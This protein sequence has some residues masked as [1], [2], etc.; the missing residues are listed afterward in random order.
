MNETCAAIE[1]I[2]AYRAAHYCVRLHGGRSVALRVGSACPPELVEMLACERT[3]VGA[4]ITAWNPFSRPAARRDNRRRQRELLDGLRS[5]GARV[6]VG[7]G[8]GEGWREPGFAAFDMH[9]AALDA[10]A[11]H[12]A[13]NAILTFCAETTVRLRLYRSDWR[14]ALAGADVDFAQPDTQ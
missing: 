3:R 1:L 5:A 11:R 2:A 9:L 8:S 10:L 4:L 13:Q 6:L 12:F 14:D 7:A